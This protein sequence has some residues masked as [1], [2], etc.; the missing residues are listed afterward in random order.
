M[1]P[2]NPFHL[3][4]TKNP[5]QQDF[6]FN[7]AMYSCYSG[8]FG[9]VAGETLIFNPHTNKSS[10]I[11]TLT[12]LNTLSY[13]S[14]DN[15][16]HESRAL[17]KPKRYN[18]KDLF[19]VETATGKRIIVTKQHKFF[20]FGWKELKDLIVGSVVMCWDKNAPHYESI[21]K[22]GFERNDYYYDLHIPGY[23]NYV[24]NGFINHN[25][26]KTFGGSVRS[27]V[28]SQ[29]PGNVGLIGRLCYDD[30]TEILTENRG[31]VFFK[32]L[33]SQDRVATLQ[34][35]EKLVYEYPLHYY[36]DRY[37][38][39]MITVQN[40]YFD[41]SV[42]PEHKMWVRWPKKKGGGK[43][44]WQKKPANT[45]YGSWDWEMKKTAQWE[46]G[47]Y[48]SPDYMEF[49]GFWFA[50]GWASTSRGRSNIILTHKDRS[51]VEDLLKRNDLSYSVYTKEPG[52]CFNF[53]LKVDH[54][55]KAMCNVLST[56][57]KALTKKIPLFIKRSNKAALLA[58]LHGF[59]IG[60]GH[61]RS[62][63]RESTQMF[64]SSYQLAC[65]LQEIL[66]KCGYAGNIKVNNNESGENSFQRNGPQYI[67]TMY[68]HQSFSVEKKHWGKMNYDGM[69]Y[70]VMVSSG[71]IYVR[72]NGK[73]VWSSNTYIE[74]RDTTRK[75]FFEVCPPEYYDASRG[76]KWSP[77][78]NY[79][80]LVNGSEILFR[81]LDT[82]SEKELLSLNLGWFYIDQA[83]EI[84]EAVF[85]T[86]QSRLR[87]NR[88]PNRYGFVTCNPEP[89]NWIYR[90]FQKPVDEGTPNP[91]FLIIN[92]STK[93]NPFN[94][95]DYYQNLLATYPEELAKRYIEG[96]WDAVENQIYTEFER[97]IHVVKPFTTPKG[98]EYVVAVDHG[99]VNPT[100]ALLGCIDFDGNLYIIDEYYSP[101]VI[102]QH[103][104][105]I[106]KMTEGY[107]ISYWMID[108][109][110]QAKTREKDG[111]PYSV[112]EEYEDYHLY[113]TPA[114]NEKIAGI[115][116]VREFLKPVANRRHPVTHKSPAPRL[117]IFQNCV[118]L[119]TELPQYKWKKLRGL[120]QKNMPEESVDYNDHACFAPDTMVH[121]REG[122]KPIQDTTTDDFVA[123]PF[124]WSR[125]LKS[126]KTGRKKV[127]DYGAFISTPN[128][129][130]LTH[131][132]IFEVD[133]L[134]YD[135]TILLCDYAKEL[136][137]MESRIEDIPRQ[138]SGLIDFISDALLIRSWEAQQGIFTEMYGS[139]I[140]GRLKRAWRSIISTA[141]LPITIYQILKNSQE[142]NIRRNTHGSLVRDILNT[143]RVLGRLL[144][145]G[146]R[147]KKERRGTA[148]TQ[149][150]L[151][152][153]ER[154][155]GRHAWYA[156]NDIPPTSL[157][158]ASTVI[159]TAKRKPFVSDVYNLQT[160][161]G[162]YFANGVLVSNC[163]ALRYMI[164]TRFS[165]PKRRLDGTQMVSLTDRRG[166]NQ[167]TTP[168]QNKGDEML[169][170]FYDD[171]G[172]S[173]NNFDETDGY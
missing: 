165:V 38:G 72:R 140:M 85:R 118:N 121:T 60:D 101:G 132:G 59:I 22:I 66:F 104:Q 42:T 52:D 17:F 139:T 79:L 50:E 93:D 136:Y 138:N 155:K 96:R 143:W 70:C 154:K 141:I 45:I 76:G 8:G 145:N 1:D 97:A 137:G 78:E 3:D 81:H 144:K 26:G 63:K 67:I 74:L 23:N 149:G 120:A 12:E 54:R 82:V 134:R 171:T 90:M 116:R 83:E 162:M 119:L 35:E 24:A 129:H 112:I 148:E 2:S 94:P 5:K 172:S 107:E 111:K 40:R 69:I 151:S 161:H 84:P 89:G 87:L 124:G 173:I 159:Q 95:E 131:K 15:S 126:G 130:I 147:V 56:C 102:S 168:M 160:E 6:V 27:L 37:K 28:L 164:V 170:N 77:S 110:T 65:D 33:T 21:V 18:K 36:S 152:R 7:K 146:M 68:Q 113:F 29:Y 34:D 133:S 31:F 105:A 122:L 117:Y 125:V 106:L 157:V 11:D 153:Y 169:G 53:R 9:C 41:M 98:W 86:L 32:D 108:P 25:S 135:D 142:R 62:N 80:R 91:N 10:R 49:L 46:G 115:N 20:S 166:G 103:A 64:T 92:S 71:L 30:K 163:D 16:L 61:Y 88:V 158:E 48:V 73:C 150:F 114:N 156:I 44:S 99:M 47:E 43:G 109:S 167:I 100:A 51:Y 55:T 39:E 57:G 14:E 127:K 128:H 13:H 4:L 19:L 58:F 75:T 123:T